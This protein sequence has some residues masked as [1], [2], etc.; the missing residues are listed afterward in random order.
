M[1][2]LYAL[3]RYKSVEVGYKSKIEVPRYVRNLKSGN[4][5]STRENGLNIR[6][7]TQMGQDE[8]SGA[9]LQVKEA[10]YIYWDQIDIELDTHV[11]DGESYG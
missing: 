2:N 1:G 7:N 4:I 11:I 9:D 8:V 10:Y 5:T 3:L 6:K